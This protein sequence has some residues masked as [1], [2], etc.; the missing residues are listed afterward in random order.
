MGTISCI[1]E[2]AY[3][4]I[5]AKLPQN[6]IHAM[7][8][9]RELR[10]LGDATVMFFDE[11]GQ[12]LAARFAD[13]DQADGAPPPQTSGFAVGSPVAA[14]LDTLPVANHPLLVGQVT[15]EDPEEWSAEVPVINRDHGTA[16]ASL[17]INGD[18]NEQ[19]A[20]RPARPLLCYPLLRPNGSGDAAFP[21]DR[22]P[23]D[24]LHVAIR[25]VINTSADRRLK[26]ITLA[27]GDPNRL[28]LRTVS[29]W[30]RLLDWLAYEHSV[31]FVISAGNPQPNEFVLTADRGSFEALDD[32]SLAA[33]VA[34][35]SHLENRNRRLLAPADSVNAL[36]VGGLYDDASTPAP[37]AGQR[38][39]FQQR[40]LP[41]PYG[42]QGFGFRQSIKP[43]IML[44]SGR[45]LYQEK[46]GTERTCQIAGVH[47]LR[48]PGQL[49]ALA[50]RN[51]RLDASGHFRGTSNAAALATR[52][53]I[54]AWNIIEELR[55]DEGYEIDHA[56][57]AV[58]IKALLAH[59]CSRSEI[60]RD[61]EQLDCF[62]K[63]QISKIARR[64]AGYGKLYD[65]RLATCTSQ[66][67]T[68]I[69]VGSLMKDEAHEYDV[70]T[71]SS[72]GP[73]TELR[74]LTI[75]LSYFTPVNVRHHLYRRAVLRAELGALHPELGVRIDET[76][77]H[78]SARGTLQHLVFAGRDAV[79]ARNGQ[80]KI[81]INCRAEAGDLDTPI[82]YALAVTIEA[83]AQSAVPVYQEVRAKVIAAAPRAPVSVPSPT[84]RRS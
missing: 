19:P 68:L 63:D 80:I 27:V 75:T 54:R 14:L 52:A 22:L 45:M 55:S 35:A 28:F 47:A 67:A 82:Q 84:V 24:A 60:E 74:R 70:P 20:E 44:P 26:L 36:T 5:L 42:A 59:A 78:D 4:G 57:D 40:N 17:I 53:G 25:N 66:R 83:D 23:I 72:L 29:K 73:T 43:D 34:Q 50:P 39:V 61:I 32:A 65:D 30:A 76:H 58:L 15:V 1:P 77:Q 13:D 81:A 21:V 56:Y 64:L 18:L 6:E 37:G 3:H 38:L 33:H 51:G 16:M 7:I 9:R 8:D 46:R 11:V 2:I 10:L 71:P 69:G 49:V 41:A 79:A 48:A 31:L 12:S 62:P